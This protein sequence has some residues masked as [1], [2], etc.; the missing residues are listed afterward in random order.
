MC[1]RLDISQL[2]ASYRT[3]SQEKTEVDKKNELL[4]RNLLKHFRMKKVFRAYNP[5]NPDLV[6]ELFKKYREALDR[7]DEVCIFTTMVFF[8]S[9]NCSCILL[10]YCKSPQ[11]VDRLQP[12]VS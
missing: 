9:L 7:L 10:D 4:N 1:E 12:Q 5:D 2:I 11:N 3:I 6:P 8:F